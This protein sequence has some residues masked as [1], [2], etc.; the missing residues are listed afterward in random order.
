MELC[1]CPKCGKPELEDAGNKFSCE[2]GFVLY[3]NTAA[4]VAVLLVSGNEILFTVRN[5]QPGLG[6]LDLP[7]GFCDPEETA[8]ITCK[9]EILEELQL[10]LNEQNFKYLG[11]RPNIYPYKNIVYHTLDLFYSY[12]LRDKPETVLEAKEIAGVKWISTRDLN[13]EDLAFESQ[14]D[15]LK[16]YLR[17]Q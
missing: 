15:F 17:N 2:C 16:Q 8:E 9:R 7:G 6:K 1:Y 11:S 10:E 14:K 12:E 13:L 3:Q 5:Q 4:A